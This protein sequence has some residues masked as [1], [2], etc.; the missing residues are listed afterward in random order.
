M[1]IIGL[2]TLECPKLHDLLDEITDGI[3]SQTYTLTK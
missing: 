1:G 3:L 2:K